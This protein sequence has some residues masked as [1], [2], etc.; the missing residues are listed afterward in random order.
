MGFKKD[1]IWGG[2]TASYQVEGAAYEDGKGLN[3]WDIFCKDG[4]HIYENQT[5]DVAC[6]QYHR[7]KEDVQIMKE[8]GMKAYRFSLSWARIMPEGTGAVNENGLE[9]YD[10]LINE[11]LDN[12]IEPFVTL[13][14]W[15]LPYALHLQGGW[16]NPNS[17][18]WFYEYA[19][20]VAEHFSDRVKNFFTINEPQCV[21][22]LGYQTGEHAPGLKVGPSDYFRIWHNVLK[23]HGRAVEA[24]REFSK[25]PV[26]IS[27]APC[28]ALY[29]PETNKPEDIE[30]A[31]KANF[32]LP[33]NSI[34]ACSWD[35]ALCCDPVYLG[36]YPEDILKEFGQFFPKVTDA[37]MKL[38]SQPLDFYGQNIYNAVTVRAGEDGKAVRA[39]RYDGFPQT[40]IGWPVTPEV[41]YWAPK[42]MQ[43]RY[44]KPF[45]ITENG[46]ASH[47]WV[48]VDG[49]VHDQAL[50][51]LCCCSVAISLFIVLGFI[52]F[53]TF[54]VCSLVGNAG[55]Q[56]LAVR[57]V[58]I[59]YNLLNFTL[60]V[61]FSEIRISKIST[62]QSD[63]CSTNEGLRK[64]FISSFPFFL[65]ADFLVCFLLHL[66][67]SL[68]C[69]AGFYFAYW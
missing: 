29:V 59:I 36:Q 68:K 5:G 60:C 64:L 43:E 69:M 22:G 10:N 54:S 48:G 13:Y 39:A 61:P 57:L 35:V 9:Y 20:V 25:Q 19:K 40:A 34:G 28:G 56:P 23:A 24:L 1:F 12:G 31:R 62:P 42:F 53:L 44:K 30:A 32:S 11:L 7:Y 51:S 14:H 63:K 47:D 6:D 58:K 15:D 33:E 17:S 66:F 3:I 55:I 2:A 52:L 16:M 4:G 8:M 27:M 49:K 65:T 41:L 37:D 26:K 50:R 38:I 45:M 46:M 21:V 67:S 18:S